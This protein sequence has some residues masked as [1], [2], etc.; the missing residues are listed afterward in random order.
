MHSI[1]IAARETEADHM[2]EEGERRQ[3]WGADDERQQRKEERRNSREGAE[4]SWRRGG[5]CG[6]EEEGREDVGRRSSRPLGLTCGSQ[7]HQKD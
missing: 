4:L 7:Q 5:D 6:K 2:P 3:A 1:L